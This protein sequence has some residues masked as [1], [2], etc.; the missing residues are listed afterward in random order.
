M[1]FAILL[2]Q[3]CSLLRKYLNHKMLKNLLRQKVCIA[4]SFLISLITFDRILTKQL[5]DQL[6]SSSL[7]LSLA[8]ELV[9]ATMSL[10]REYR[11]NIY[12]KKIYD[13]ALDVAKLHDIAIDPSRWEEKKEKATKSTGRQCAT[14]NSWIS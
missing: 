3:F 6:Q 14:G 12:W 4:F 1:L 10:L 13:Y 7:D 2:T 11:S 5:S 9:L 8:S